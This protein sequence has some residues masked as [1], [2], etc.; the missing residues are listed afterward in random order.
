MG[1]ENRQQ[2]GDGRIFTQEIAKTSSQEAFRILKM[3]RSGVIESTLG[4][5]PPVH[6]EAKGSRHRHP[7]VS[8]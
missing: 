4:L 3:S 8:S 2:A 1:S 7:L 6:P 5:V